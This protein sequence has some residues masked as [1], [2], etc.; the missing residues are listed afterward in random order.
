MCVD[1][2]VSLLG[3]MCVNECENT[4]VHEIRRYGERGD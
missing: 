2:C 3:V 1:I 4:L